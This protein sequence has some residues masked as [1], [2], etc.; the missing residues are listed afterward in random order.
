MSFLLNF[1]EINDKILDTPIYRVF[2]LDKFLI[3]LNQNS[4]HLIK[5]R[6]WE[7]PF[8]GFLLNQVFW[9]S[10][11]KGKYY[12]FNDF[13]RERFYGQCWTFRNESDFLW[14]IYAPNKDG[15]MVKSSIR[16]FND[17]FQ[18]M[19]GGNTYFG[20]VN[21]LTQEEIA[22]KFSLIESKDDYENLIIDSLL[23]KRTEFMEEQELR[24]LY[25]SKNS[26]HKDSTP[27][28]LGYDINVK[29]IGDV[30]FDE[31][32]VDPRIDLVR[33]DY[34]RKIIKDLGFNGKI[35]RSLLYDKPIIRI[36]I[37]E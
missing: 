6:L 33:F 23:L 14:R 5:P 9:S 4:L 7:D 30:L 18:D 10:S 31:I 3:S 19:P 25:F 11:E 29:K 28:G 36:H 35:D 8:E 37:N 24:L 26:A 20:K 13:Y 15:I 12:E 17:N 22:K 27:I 2:S 34:L 32:L 21:Y 16:R 1:K